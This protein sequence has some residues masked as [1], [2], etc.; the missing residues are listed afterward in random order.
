MPRVALFVLALTVLAV[1]AGILFMTGQSVAT[2]TNASPA[3]SLGE[4]RETA[5]TTTTSPEPAAIIPTASS[6][7]GSDVES[8]LTT[9]T[10]T[11]EDHF[12]DGGGKVSSSGY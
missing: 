6:L 4:S 1:G 2:A 9:F 12:C 10:Y 3:T 8:E 11:S 7:Y 5:L